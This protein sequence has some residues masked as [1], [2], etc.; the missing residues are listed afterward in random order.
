MNTQ[1]IP[2]SK[3]RRKLT[4]LIVSVNQP[5]GQPVLISVLG[6]PAVALISVKTYEDYLKKKHREEFHEIFDELDNLNKVL[7]N[8]K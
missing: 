1:T 3:A 6:K 4:E 7:A 2:L 8:K 5:N